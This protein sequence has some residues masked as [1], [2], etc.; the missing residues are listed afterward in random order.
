MLWTTPL[1][2]L[3][4]DVIYGWSLTIALSNINLQF[5]SLKDGDRFFFTHRDGFHF[6][7][8]PFTGVQLENIK[9]YSYII[10][11]IYVHDQ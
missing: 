2:P 1:P 4:H 10:V 11:I 5:K 9:V 6:N 7:P 3:V 8:N